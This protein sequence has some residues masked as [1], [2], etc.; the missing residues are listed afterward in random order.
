MENGCVSQRKPQGLSR[1]PAHEPND[2]NGEHEDKL[3]GEPESYPGCLGYFN[4]KRTRCQ[5]CEF[6]EI[7]KKVVPRNEVEK[8]LQ[9]LLEVATKGVVL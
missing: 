5:K 3:Y 6:L 4:K 2:C 9:Q 1:L 8:L 7:C